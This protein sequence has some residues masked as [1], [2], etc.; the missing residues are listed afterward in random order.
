MRFPSDL[1]QVAQTIA[2]WPTAPYHEGLIRSAAFKLLRGLPHLTLRLDPFGNVIAHYR[3]RP[4][5][6]RALALVAHMDHPGFVADQFLGGVSPPYFKGQRV[7]FFD[8]QTGAALGSRRIQKIAFTNEVKKVNWNR[9]PPAGA[10]GMWNLPAFA[11]TPTHFHSRACDDLVGV[12]TIIALLRHLSRQ[13]ARANVY[14]LLTRAEEVGFQGTL[15]ALSDRPPF[16]K[17]PVLSLE[18]S[19]AQGFATPGEGPI[20]RVGDRT[21]V[22]DSGVTHW[23]QSAAQTLAKRSKQF[24]FQRLLMGGGTCEG[25]PFHL[26]GYPT[27]AL[28]LALTNYHNMGPRHKITSENVRLDDWH[29]LLLLLQHLATAQGVEPSLRPLRSRLRKLS[30]TGVRQLKKHPLSRLS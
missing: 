2:T 25:T 14:G 23:L 13:K 8:P 15:A 11:F 12:S 4:T 16:P 7:A 30:R 18:T 28:C 1:K 27:G 20:I 26:A 19:Q 3:Y 24:R 9:P 10:I 5:P 6:G 22:F 21:S 17:I 29:N